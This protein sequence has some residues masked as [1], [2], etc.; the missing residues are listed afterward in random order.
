MKSRGLASPDMADTL[1]MT[2][3]G[4][5]RH[6]A[7]PQLVYSFPGSDQPRWMR[8]GHGV[9]APETRS[10]H[11]FSPITLEVT[12]RFQSPALRSTKQLLHITGTDPTF[13]ESLD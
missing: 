5:L 10:P 4:L 13:R 6:L 1:A 7:A 12:Q 3:A 8:W 2:F 11:A 9:R